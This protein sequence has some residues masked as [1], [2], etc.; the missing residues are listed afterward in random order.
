MDH[1]GP[2][3]RLVRTVAARFDLA[4]R[5]DGETI[6][7]DSMETR[8]YDMPLPS[9]NG[10]LST[11]LSGV[12]VAG[13]RVSS[14]RNVEPDPWKELAAALEPA[15]RPRGRIALSPTPA[16]WRYSRRHRRR[17]SSRRS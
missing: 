12:N 3:S 2:L 11:T 4:W 9:A 17:P 1:K 7:F 16:R 13:N 15:F 8:S 10:A 6:L 5:F 14:T